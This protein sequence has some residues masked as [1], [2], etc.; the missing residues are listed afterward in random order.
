MRAPITVAD[1]ERWEDHG[2]SWRTISCD[3]QLAVIE[4]CTCHGEAVDVGRS[5]APEL[6][7][8]VRARRRG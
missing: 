4:L 7:E 5:D 6:I 3:D 1:L 8:F 2:A